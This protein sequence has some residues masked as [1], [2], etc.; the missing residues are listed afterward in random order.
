MTEVK[1]YVLKNVH[2]IVYFR[3]VIT[4]NFISTA[5]ED[6]ETSDR[7]ISSMSIDRLHELKSTAWDKENFLHK[8]C[9]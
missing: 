8:A 4:Y 1:C 5:A 3:N 9:S 7:L 2:Y 6:D